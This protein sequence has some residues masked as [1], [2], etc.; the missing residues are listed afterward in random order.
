MSPMGRERKLASGPRADIS[1]WLRR[2]IV[3]GA[4]KLGELRPTFIP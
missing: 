2:S 4:V 3:K 1:G